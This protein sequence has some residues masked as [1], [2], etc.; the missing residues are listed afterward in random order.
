MEK[1]SVVETLN[2]SNNE[3]YVTP[4]T[5]AKKLSGGGRNTQ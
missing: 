5:L 1:A 4:F 2:G 3:K